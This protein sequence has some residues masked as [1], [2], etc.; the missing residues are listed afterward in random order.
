[1]HTLWSNNSKPKIFTRFFSIGKLFQLFLHISVLYSFAVRWSI[2]PS[3]QQTKWTK[4]KNKSR[5]K[6]RKSKFE[7]ELILKNF[8]EKTMATYKSLNYVHRPLKNSA[9]HFDVPWENARCAPDYTY[10]KKRREEF[11]QSYGSNKD[12]WTFDFS[13]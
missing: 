3:F 13:H 7:P 6:P 11:K 10:Y 9:F 8:P 1:M 4:L 2:L 5:V 12:M